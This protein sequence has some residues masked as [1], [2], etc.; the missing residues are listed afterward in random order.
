[1]YHRAEKYTEN[2]AKNELP[3]KIRICAHKIRNLRI[4]RSTINF[5]NDLGQ[6]RII[7]VLYHR[8]EKHTE[9]SAKNEYQA[10]FV[11][12][13]IKYAICAFCVPL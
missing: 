11:F 6:M 9:N 1:M 8:A 2:T 13:H 12:A 7:C 5:V 3:G 10:K 4:L